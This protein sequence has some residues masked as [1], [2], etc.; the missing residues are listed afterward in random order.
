MTRF[1]KLALIILAVG[2]VATAIPSDSETYES[3]PTYTPSP[4]WFGIDLQYATPR[5]T[6]WEIAPGQTTP[7]NSQGLHLG[8]DWITPFPWGSLSLGLGVTGSISANV[9]VGKNPN[10]SERFTSLTAI[11]VDVSLSYRFEYAE[12]Q[13][14]VPF[15]RIGMSA[16]FVGQT[17][18]TGAG[19]SATYVGAG[20]DWGVGMEFSLH[21]LDRIS[22]NLFDSDFGVNHTFLTI[23]YLESKALLNLSPHNL[24]RKEI[25]AGLRFEL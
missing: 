16:T 12:N 3:A 17:S 20:L 22:Q 18:K 13:I 8:V 5:Y 9:L 7:G 19:R 23:E 2:Q 21:A 11:P 14:L 6:S 25:R 4:L 1:L 24:A 10:G 15:A